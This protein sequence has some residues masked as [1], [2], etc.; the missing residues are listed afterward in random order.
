M[1]VHAPKEVHLLDDKSNEQPQE[2]ELEEENK[3]EVVSENEAS[4]NKLA[5]KNISDAEVCIL[6]FHFIYILL[7]LCMF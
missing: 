6:L 1:Q 4:E 5:Y 7:N 2:T 3:E